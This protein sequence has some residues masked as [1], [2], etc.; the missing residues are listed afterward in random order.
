[1]NLDGTSL[2]MKYATL[3]IILLIC[4][5]PAHFTPKVH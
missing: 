1:M 5:A 3:R 2:Y 4:G